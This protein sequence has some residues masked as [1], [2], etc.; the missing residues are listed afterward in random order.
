[1]RSD[2]KRHEEEKHENNVEYTCKKEDCKSRSHRRRKAFNRH[3]NKS[4]EC[5]KKSVSA[6]NCRTYIGLKKAWGCGFCA[7]TF[8]KWSERVAHV[9]KHQDEGMQKIEWSHSRVILGLLNQRAME[10]HW[11]YLK[12]EVFEQIYPGSFW[13]PIPTMKLQ[14]DLE[15]GG[16]GDKARL[17]KEAQKLLMK[18]SSTNYLDYQTPY[19]TLLSSSKSLPTWNN[20]RQNEPTK[21][22]DLF[23]SSMAASSASALESPF[24]SD[25]ML[26]M[27]YNTGDV[28]SSSFQ[29]EYAPAMNFH[30]NQTPQQSMTTPIPMASIDDS[31]GVPQAAAL[32]PENEY[33]QPF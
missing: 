12:K 9:G 28:S 8:Y 13:E 5:K 14:D 1:M 6:A 30:D 23:C 18:G 27:V 4:D 16:P 32:T 7:E 20:P 25:P 2:W 17:V 3:I 11:T 33:A 19:S 31:Y 26:P 29:P 22:S 21:S 24:I 15:H 10:E